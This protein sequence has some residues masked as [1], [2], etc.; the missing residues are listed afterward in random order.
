MRQDIERATPILHAGRV[1]VS[2]T[3]DVQTYL[4]FPIIYF[5]WEGGGRRVCVCVEG[6]CIEG[7]KVPLYN[8]V[9]AEGYSL[10]RE[11]CPV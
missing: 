8:G 7:G 1:C 3:K 11:V 10:Y 5:V 9:C 6:G 4:R 2:Q